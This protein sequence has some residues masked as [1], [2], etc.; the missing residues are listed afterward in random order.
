MAALVAGQLRGRV[1]TLVRDAGLPSLATTSCRLFS[2]AAAPD[3]DLVVVGGGPG[4]YVAAIKAAQLGMKVTCVEKRG[5]LG[6]TCLN[7]GCIPS[8][9]R[10]H[11]ASHAL[12]GRTAPTGGRGRRPRRWQ[13]LV[14]VWHQVGGVNNSRVGLVSTPRVSPLAH[15]LTRPAP[16]ATPCPQALLNS[17]QMYED[18]KH[19]FAKHGVKVGDLQLDLSVMM[20]QKTQAVSGLTKGIE[21]LFKKNKVKYVKGAGS[22]TGTPGEVVVTGLDGAQSTLTTK[23]VL[24]ATGSEVMPLPGVT[25][26]EKRIVS[27]TGALSLA[28]VPKH[29]VVIGAGVIGLELGSVWRRL[30]SAVTVVEYAPKLLGMVDEDARASFQKTLTKAGIKFKFGTKV[31]GVKDTGSGVQVSVQAAAGGETETMEADVCLVAIGRKPHTASLN[32]EAAGVKTDKAGRVVVDTHTF[33]TSAPG[34]Y[35]IGDIVAGPMLAHKAEEEGIACVEHLAG[36][37]GHVNY[38]TIPSIIYTHPEVAWVGKTEEEVKAAGLPYKVGKFPFLANSRARTVEDADG[39]VKFI[40]H[41]ETDEILGVHIVGASA[42]E[43]IAECVLAMEYGGSAE[44]I[45]RTCHGHPTL[46][47]AVKEA[48]MAASIGKAIH[49]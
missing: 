6:G 5:A 45:A 48:A 31:T 18:A 3:N 15:G 17:S 42:G 1:A 23:N 27:S 7:V 8:K 41:A 39:L 29:L 25:I 36:L 47:E 33:A 10:P 21:G 34:V 2:A 20:A 13:A 44:D 49:I 24:L 40:S 37:A 32:L 35:A 38:A 28:E 30:G 26:D 43:M 22:L 19:S 14:G 46:T 4:G 11:T 9:V 16:H 12:S